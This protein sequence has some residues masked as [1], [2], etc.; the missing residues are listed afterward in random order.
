MNKYHALSLDPGKHV[1]EKD[2]IEK[3]CFHVGFHFHF[4]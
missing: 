1:S 3:K 4:G 2:K